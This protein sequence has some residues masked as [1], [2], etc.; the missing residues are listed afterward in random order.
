MVFGARITFAAMDA[1]DFVVVAV[2]VDLVDFAAAVFR[3][4]W[5][6]RSYWCHWCCCCR[7]CWCRLYVRCF[8]VAAVIFAEDFDAGLVVLFS[9]AVKSFCGGATEASSL[10]LSLSFQCGDSMTFLTLI[11]CYISSRICFSSRSVFVTTV[12]SRV[13]T[14]EDPYVNRAAQNTYRVETSRVIY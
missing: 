6:C 12:L 3:L 13:V 11:K 7:F 9:D 5:C 10:L 1:V 14:R 2:V 8:V 4:C